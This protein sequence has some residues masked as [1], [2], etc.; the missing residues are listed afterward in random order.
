MFQAWRR[1]FPRPLWRLCP[2]DDHPRP[3]TMM[4]VA[5]WMPVEPIMVTVP[6]TMSMV[7]MAARQEQCECRDSKQLFHSNR[8]RLFH[9]LQV[10]DV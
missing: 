8:S 10:F 2:R 5:V 4:F 7:C 1:P 3:M 9:R 6:L